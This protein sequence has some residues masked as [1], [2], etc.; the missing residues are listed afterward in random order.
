MQG[1][2]SKNRRNVKQPEKNPSPL[3]ASRKGGL[4]LSLSQTR[5][6][7][8]AKPQPRQHP[9]KPTGEFLS[10]P[11]MSHPESAFYQHV[12]RVQM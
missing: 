6:S 12:R 7:T 11:R 2:A 8:E 5:D 4:S 3:F 1:G 9:S 10:K